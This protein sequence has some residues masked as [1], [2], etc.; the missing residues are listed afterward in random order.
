MTVD[1]SNLF[2]AITAKPVVT[3]EKKARTP[4]ITTEIEELA[5]ALFEKAEDLESETGSFESAP[6]PWTLPQNWRTVSYALRT[7][8]NEKLILA[9]SGTRNGKGVTVV[10]GVE[11]PLLRITSAR[12]PQRKSK[13]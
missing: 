4:K 12:H 11:V 2:A 1:V 5:T 9:S 8:S 13:E 3:K 7:L 10:D 6:F